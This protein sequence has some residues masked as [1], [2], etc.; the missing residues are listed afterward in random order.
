MKVEP[1]RQVLGI[2]GVRALM[3]V[4]LVARIPVTATGLTLTLHVVNGMKLGFAQAGLVGAAST[5]GVAVGAP[6]AGRFVDRHGLRPVVLVTTAAQIAFWG[7]AAFLPY[8]LLLPGAFLGGLLALPVFSVIR[9]CVAA[10][11]PVAQRRAGFALDS[12]FV[13]VAYMIGPALAV[14]LSTTAGNEWAM[15]LVGLGLAGSGTAL[16]ALNPPTRTAEEAEILAEPVRRRQWLTP[17]L[18]ALLGV[19]SAA[20]FVLSATELSMVAVLKHDGAAAWTGLAVALWCLWSLLGGFVYGGLSRG[21][22]PLV[23][24]GAMAAL[25]IPVGLVGDWRLLCLALIPSGMFCAP[26]LSTTADTVSQWVPPSA[27]GEAMGLHGTAL[28]L[29]L[30]VSGPIAGFLIDSYGTGWSFA[31]AGLIS[32]VLVTAAAPFWRRAP[33][34]IAASP[35]PEPANAQA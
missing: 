6:V 2:P 3:L 26:A 34:P 32:V 23:T 29:G 4:G 28:T 20:T 35:T 19:T 25:T 33:E 13:E 16:L 30:S 5:V 12:M 22:S 27:H 14:G 17:A 21:F 8:F 18:L 7:C 11:V 24:V 9:Q 15:A 31:V 10:A 1:Y